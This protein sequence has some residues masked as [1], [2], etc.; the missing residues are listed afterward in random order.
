M[1]KRKNMKKAE[2]TMVQDDGYLS[3]LDIVCKD[4]FVLTEINDMA[5]EINPFLGAVIVVS[6]PDRILEIN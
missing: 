4:E 2:I 3:T 1:E 5:I 6:L